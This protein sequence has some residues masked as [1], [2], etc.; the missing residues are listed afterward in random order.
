MV[1]QTSP[2]FIIQAS[3][4]FTI[5]CGYEHLSLEMKFNMSTWGLS[6]MANTEIN[7][8]IRGTP[9]HIIIYKSYKLMVHF[10]VHIVYQ[11]TVNIS[12]ECGNRQ[13]DEQIGEI[14]MEQTEHMT[15]IKARI[16][17]CMKQVAQLS[18]RYRA[19]GW[20]S[21]G[22]KWKTGTGRQYLRTI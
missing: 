9:F 5:K 16:Q 20:V 18:Q 11:W 4:T 6:H 21:Y 13:Y 7:I 3:Q 22:Q 15:V 10:V 17:P 12:S 14:N 2:I 1:K 19:A 8:L